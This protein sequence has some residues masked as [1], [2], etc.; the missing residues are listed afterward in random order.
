MSATINVAQP[1]SFVVAV[2]SYG[3]TSAPAGMTKLG[4]TDPLSRAYQENVSAGS[5]TADFGAGNVTSVASFSAIPE[6]SAV[7]L[8][9]LGGLLLLRRRRG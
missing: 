7:L 9:S 8:G 1:G 2:N 5:F 6:P 3:N 4:G